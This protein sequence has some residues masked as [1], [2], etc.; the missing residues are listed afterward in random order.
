M[1]E[2][3][4]RQIAN[5]KP[6]LGQLGCFQETKV[7]ENVW[8]INLIGQKN[9]RSQRSMSGDDVPP[10]RYPAVNAALIEFT[11]HL[12]KKY[13]ES[14]KEVVI[15]CPLMGAGLAGGDWNTISALIEANL[16]LRGFP[17]EVYVLANDP[18][19]KQLVGE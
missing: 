15:Q 2:H 7:E 10:I 16:I 17:V 6:T 8:V 3:T 18:K 5:H 19:V 13:E 4:F 14:S 1:P 12:M 9:I 11:K